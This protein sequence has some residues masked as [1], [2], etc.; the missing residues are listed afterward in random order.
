MSKHTY[1]DPNWWQT[2]TRKAGRAACN[3]HED[4]TDNP[5]QGQTTASGHRCHALWR[6][7]WMARYG[8]MSKRKTKT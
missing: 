3:R 2:A 8:E 5:Y 4:I 7:G 6:A 1:D